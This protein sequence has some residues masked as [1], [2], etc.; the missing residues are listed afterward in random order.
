MPIGRPTKLSPE[1]TEKICAAIRV[2][3]YMETAAA[4]AGIHKDTLYA[5]LKSGANDESPEHV[6]FSDSV[7]KALAEA[8]VT[9]VE[10]INAAGAEQWQ[11]LAWRLERRFPDRWG[12]RDRVE[13]TVN[14]N[15]QDKAQLAAEGQALGLTPE[16][17]F[18]R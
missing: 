7:Q 6:A 8:E 14:L 17:L 11:A 3:C 5:W 4:N 2:G 16:V 13:N 12:R 10:R 9:A 1:V 18:G 15:V